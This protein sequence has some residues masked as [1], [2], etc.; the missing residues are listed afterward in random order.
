LAT[1]H[2]RP[3]HRGHRNEPVSPCIFGKC[4]VILTKCREV[5]V[6]ASRAHLPAVF[7]PAVLRNR[8]PAAGIGGRSVW[9]LIPKDGIQDQARFDGGI[10]DERRLFY[11]AMTRSQKLSQSH[12]E[13]CVERAC[14]VSLFLLIGG[15]PREQLSVFIQAYL[16]CGFS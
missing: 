11:V 3:S 14:H 15:W 10:E 7:I 1:H 13:D 4:R 6:L 2:V 8:F 9:H 5:R 16:H 12:D